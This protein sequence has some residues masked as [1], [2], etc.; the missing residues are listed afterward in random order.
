MAVGAGK[1]MM[2]LFKVEV[3]IMMLQGI[4]LKVEFVEFVIQILKK[5]AKLASEAEARRREAWAAGDIY[6]NCKSPAICN[7]PKIV[8]S[9]RPAPVVFS[10]SLWRG[11]PR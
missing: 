6:L 4:C 8:R 10:P 1:M 3:A 5:A 7:H 9:C 11:F 2:H